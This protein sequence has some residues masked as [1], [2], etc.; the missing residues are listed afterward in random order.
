[1]AEIEKSLSIYDLPLEDRENSIQ[2]TAISAELTESEKSEDVKFTPGT[3]LTYQ[4]SDLGDYYICTGFEALDNSKLSIPEKHNGKYIKAIAANA[5][6][7][8]TQLEEITLSPYI[9]SIGEKAFYN[10]SI[11]EVIFNGTSNLKEIGKNAF[12]LSEIETITIPY[13]VTSIGNGAFSNCPL[14][15][16]TF[17][18]PEKITIY[19]HTTENKMGCWYT[20]RNSNDSEQLSERITMYLAGTDTEGYI[21]KA[22][23]PNILQPG[24][25]KIYFSSSEALGEGRGYEA[26]NGIIDGRCFILKDNAYDLDFYEYDSDVEG[27]TIGEN[28][29]AFSK[30]ASLDLPDKV[31]VI[32]PRAFNSC[33]LLES[34]STGRGIQSIGSSAFLE[35]TS[36]KDVVLG[37]RSYIAG[38]YAWDHALSLHTIGIAAFADCNN[39]RGT[40]YIPASVTCIKAG[41]FRNAFNDN[42]QNIVKFEQKYGWIVN[43]SGLKPDEISTS[44][45]ATVLLADNLAQWDWTRITQMI[46]PTITLDED[47]RILTITD[48]TG[49]AEQF[50][51]YI[52]G[53]H[54]RTMNALTG[55]LI[56]A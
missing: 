22:T 28:A 21:Y 32:M 52:N 49:L 53:N 38:A 35:C 24:R 11:K 10:S 25:S 31:E 27:M 39:I 43:E 19:L 7:G 15:N 18:K 6:Y 14:T 33:G 48:K 30:I 8:C 34:V 9:E 44:Y 16:C 41:A 2:V 12:S 54:L 29:F 50:Y 13:S 20:Y 5:F 3:V 55:E 51:I 26:R 4:A 23:I 1:M 37:A 36:L 47:A 40:L 17:E 56:P 45:I 42:M 46:A